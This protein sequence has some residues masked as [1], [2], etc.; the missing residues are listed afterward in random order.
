MVRGMNEYDSRAVPGKAGAPFGTSCDIAAVVQ[1]T[2]VSQERCRA[3][4]GAVSRLVL[5][6]RLVEDTI[7]P[8]DMKVGHE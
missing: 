3:V 1:V 7:R 5:V 4:H 2:W 8:L 6:V